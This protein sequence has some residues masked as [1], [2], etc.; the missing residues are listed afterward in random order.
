MAPSFDCVS[1]L[2]CADED[3]TVFDD[4]D[5]AGS[6]AAAEVPEVYDET[7]R[8]S[9]YHHQRSQ[10]FGDPDELPLL[11]DE[12]LAVMVEKECQFWPGADYLNKFRTRDL[13]FGAR[14]EAIDWIQKVCVLSSMCCFSSE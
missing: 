14:N 3:S 12:C 9:R 6:A 2:L 10:G 1:S 8:R 13:D 4:G 5:Y 11:S 7:W